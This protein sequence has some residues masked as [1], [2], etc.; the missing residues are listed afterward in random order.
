MAIFLSVFLLWN[1]SH[2]KD[3]TSSKVELFD[4]HPWALFWDLSGQNVTDHG[5]RSW[6]NHKC[7]CFWEQ[8]MDWLKGTLKSET[9]DF[10]MKHGLFMV[11]LVFPYKYTQIW[12]SPYLFL[13]R[14]HRYFFLYPWKWGC[15]LTWDECCLPA[16][17][18]IIETYSHQWKG[19]CPIWTKKST[20][21]WTA[22]TKSS[23]SKLQ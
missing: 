19:S 13:I 23:S 8:S 15:G 17:A 1:I 5:G 11:F 22:K 20:C 12:R 18:P 16:L 2:Q 21:C 9:L 7:F 6:W 3:E 4:W 14:I 10:S